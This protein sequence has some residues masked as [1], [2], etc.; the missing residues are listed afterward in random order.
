M[1]GQ[2][3]SNGINCN[4][5]SFTPIQRVPNEHLYPVNYVCTEYVHYTAQ[6]LGIQDPN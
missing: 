2:D 5:G 1:L 6:V 3:Y 4:K